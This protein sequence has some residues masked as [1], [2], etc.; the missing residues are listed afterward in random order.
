MSDYLPLHMRIFEMR[1]TDKTGYT[2]SMPGVAISGVDL[3]LGFENGEWV[4]SQTEHD[5]TWTVRHE[6]Q[7][8]AI[9]SLIALRMGFDAQLTPSVPD[10]EE[11]S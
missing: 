1:D 8:A 4:V 9:L 7:K 2:I 11:G 5:T 3:P 10:T 6:W